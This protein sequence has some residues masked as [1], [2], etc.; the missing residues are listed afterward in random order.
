[1]ESQGRR[2]I[3]SSQGHT[4]TIRSRYGELLLAVLAVALI[5]AGAVGRRPA[6]AADAE[7]HRLY[8]PAVLART[9]PIFGLDTTSLSPERGLDS[10]LA[11][12]TSWVRASN[13]FWRDVEPQEGQPYQWDTPSVQRAEQ[14]MLTASAHGLKLILVVRASPTWATAPYQADC[15]PINPAKYAR[16]AA[17][18]AAAVDRY[19]RPPYNVEFW[20]IGN[21]PDAPIFASDSGYGCWGVASDPYYGGRA[22]GAML[23]LIY[24]AMKAVAGQI[25]V[26]NGGLLLDA[27]YNPAKSSTRMARFLEGMFVAGAGESFDILSF[28]SYSFYNDTVD[29]ARGAT[30]WKVAY[31]RELMDRYGV[32][33]KPM[34]NTEA[35]LLCSTLT[36]ECYEAQ[37]N[38]LGRFYIRAIVD[39]LLGHLWYIYDSDEFHHTALVEPAD[40][41]VQRPTYHAY[42]HVAQMLA[43]ARLL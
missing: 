29:G 5:V 26:L 27:P 2:S 1:M 42:R 8:L 11:L 32:P 10:L 15:A 39:E 21:E 34:L 3:H 18:L 22:Y 40:V 38:A 28:H 12:G 7:L 4:R 14:D 41:T 9:Q 31:L 19:S 23:K 6:R 30:D 36:A 13:L 25:N 20:E 33:R 17:F 37:A 16:F 24:P 35:A 43:G